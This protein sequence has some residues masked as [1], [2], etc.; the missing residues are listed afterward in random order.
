[1]NHFKILF[2][3]ICA[4]IVCLLQSN[5]IAIVIH[6]LILFHNRLLNFF[7]LKIIHFKIISNSNVKI[8]NDRFP[9][10]LV[11]HLVDLSSVFS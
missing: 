6:F 5:A 3:K 2:R 9:I 10:H 11:S 8:K 4:G 7:V 1:M